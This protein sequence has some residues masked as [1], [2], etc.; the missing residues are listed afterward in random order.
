MFKS[1]IFSCLNFQ[2][3]DAHPATFEAYILVPYLFEMLFQI[4]FFPYVSN[5]SVPLSISSHIYV[6][7]HCFLLSVLGIVASCL[8]I[9]TV[10]TSDWSISH[11]SNQEFIN[12]NLTCAENFQTY[13][14]IKTYKQYNQRFV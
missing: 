13:R 5:H 8:G 3:E 11:V 2:F 1:S 6:F 14:N 7:Q 12:H 4:L 10:W 9:M